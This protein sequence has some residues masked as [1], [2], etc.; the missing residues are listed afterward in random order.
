M[1]VWLIAALMLV[2]AMVPCM[3]VCALAGEARA[4]AAVDV[5]SSLLTSV[6]M[7]LA[8]GFDRQPFIDLALTFA[9]ISVIGALA[10]ARMMEHD[11]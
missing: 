1:N 8:I 3:A 4:L 5:A 2:L 7:L 10:F 11:I 9:V 6:L